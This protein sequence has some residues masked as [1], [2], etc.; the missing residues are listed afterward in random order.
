MTAQYGTRVVGSAAAEAHD[1]AP[2]ALRI[3][4]DR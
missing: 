3:V 2:C 1:S 4:K